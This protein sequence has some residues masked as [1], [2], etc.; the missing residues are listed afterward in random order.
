MDDV[1]KYNSYQ[2]AGKKGGRPKKK[3]KNAT[4]G[5]PAGDQRATSGRTQGGGFKQKQRTSKNPPEARSQKP[6]TLS[7]ERGASANSVKVLF[8]IGVDILAQ[9]GSTERQSRALVGKWRKKLT[10]ERLA[11]ILIA[12]KSKTD[13]AAYITKA[14]D[15][16]AVRGGGKPHPDAERMLEDAR[17]KEFQ[18]N[19]YWDDAWGPRPEAPPQ[20]TAVA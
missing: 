18:D 15:R 8:D 20:S 17:L 2:E 11:S 6:E 1:A 19:G 14:V 7:K 16:A 12:A 3:D 9:A 5:R 4:S 13:P 10:D